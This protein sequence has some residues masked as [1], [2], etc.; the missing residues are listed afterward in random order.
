AYLGGREGDLPVAEAICADGLA[1]PIYAELSDEQQA[2]VVE[3]MQRF[4]A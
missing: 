1:L 2:Y 3:T 4:Y